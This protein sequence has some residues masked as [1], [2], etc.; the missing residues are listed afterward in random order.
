MPQLKTRFSAVLLAGALA[1]PVSASSV[2]DATYTLATHRA[3]AEPAMSPAERFM[4]VYFASDERAAMLA[5]LRER[6]PFV[7]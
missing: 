3:M 2:G 7:R 6:Y 5:R 4:A 1:L